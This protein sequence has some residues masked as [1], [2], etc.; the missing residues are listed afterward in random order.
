MVDNAAAT[1]DYLFKGLQS[2][3]QKYPGEFMNLRGKDRGTL[4]AFDHPKRD[5]FLVAAKTL[6]VNI[7]GSGASA[8]RL[9]PMLIFQKH[10]A[11]LLLERIDKLAA[12]MA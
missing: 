12:S 7:G 5:Q 8:V 2:L 9:R 3:G 1:G 6:G 11:D 10:H 4:I